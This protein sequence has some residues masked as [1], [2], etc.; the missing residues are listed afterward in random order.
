MPTKNKLLPLSSL[1]S[2]CNIPIHWINL[3]YSSAI[4]NNMSESR[5]P[6]KLELADC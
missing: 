4:S 3:N 1:E 2:K 6:G 5:A